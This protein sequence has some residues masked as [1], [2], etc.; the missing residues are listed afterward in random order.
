MVCV[1]CGYEGGV[2]TRAIH[3]T[4]IMKTLLNAWNVNVNVIPESQKKPIMP[5]SML[6]NSV[7]AGVFDSSVKQWVHMV[8]G[9]WT[10]GTRCPNVDTMSTFDVSGASHPQ[11][12]DNVV[13]KKY[14][15][16]FDN[17]FHIY[18][19]VYFTSRFV[20]CVNVVVV[21]A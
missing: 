8:C 14:I 6:L 18:L 19:N 2:M 21:V 20:Q 13:I 17:Y 9:L 7:T 4:N 12:N 3:T 5:S 15:Y 1:L 10:P 11:G 16:Y